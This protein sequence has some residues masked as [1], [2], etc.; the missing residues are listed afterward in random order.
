MLYHHKS[1]SRGNDMGE[2]KIERFK[3]E[4]NYLVKKWKITN[5]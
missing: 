3:S 5:E 1:K 2:D 4:I